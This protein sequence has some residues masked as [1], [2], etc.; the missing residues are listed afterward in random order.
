MAAKPDTILEWFRKLVAWKFD[1]SKSR[2]AYGRPDIDAG[3]VREKLEVV[4]LFGLFYS[5]SSLSFC[6]GLR[7]WVS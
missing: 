2:R 4:V 5:A 7:L 3:F 6:T 1:G